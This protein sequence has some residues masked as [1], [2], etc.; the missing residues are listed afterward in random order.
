MQLI[1]H[2]DIAVFATIHKV[3]KRPGDFG[4]DSQAKC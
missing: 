4:R 2:L 3:Q 1:S